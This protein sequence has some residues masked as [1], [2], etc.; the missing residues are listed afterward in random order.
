MVYD[1]A[2]E[3][4]DYP[5]ERASW[6]HTRLIAC[7]PFR[8]ETTP[9]F[10]V[11]L[12]PSDPA[13]GAW[14]DSGAQLRGGFVA[15]LAHLRGEPEAA[16]QA[17]LR[18]KYGAGGEDDTSNTPILRVPSLAVA[19]VRPSLP[20]PDPC[21][22]P[23]LLSRSI[24]AAVQ[25]LMRTSE[26]D[27]RVAIPWLSADGR[28]LTVKYRSVAEKSFRYQDGGRPVRELLYGLHAL[29]TAPDRSIVALVEA[30]ID[31]MT[32]WAAGIPAL[33]TGGA[34]FNDIKR[35]LLAQLPFG[36]LMIVRDND[37]PGRAWQRA[38]IEAM[39]GRMDVMI[40]VVPARYKDV[41][42][43]GNVAPLK[44]ISE[45]KRKSVRTATLDLLI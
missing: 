36:A 43:W 11:I 9:S 44:N 19:E 7:S 40:G 38:V 26:R 32:L 17:Y 34:R 39:Y 6:S 41:N 13:Y 5:W 16:T 25:T 1:V 10:Y 29:R 45:I 21:F 15:L 42:A 24:P 18:A 2:E 20:L 37:G 27:G 23:Y 22:S 8:A 3:L 28:V 31:A 35:D 12:D 33:A 30:E 4:A 14:G